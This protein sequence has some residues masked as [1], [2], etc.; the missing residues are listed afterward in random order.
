[1]EF[2]TSKT[3]IMNNLFHQNIQFVLKLKLNDTLIFGS[4]LCYDDVDDYDFFEVVKCSP[5]MKV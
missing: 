1:M 5:N 3:T 4:M 2:C